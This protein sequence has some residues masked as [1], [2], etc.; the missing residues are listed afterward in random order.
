MSSTLMRPSAAENVRS[1]SDQR[2]P[3]HVVD[4]QR[5]GQR[6]LPAV[7]GAVGGVQNIFGAD[8]AFIARDLVAAVRSA[9]AAQD[10][11]A[12]KRLQHRLEMSRGKLV[13]RR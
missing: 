12:H 6:R 5:S 4:Q 8:A 1:A 10:A 7:F 11:V 9:H 13:A 2:R 3:D